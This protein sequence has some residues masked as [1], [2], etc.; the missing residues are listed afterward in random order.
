M[1]LLHPSWCS[2]SCCCLLPCL[3]VLFLPSPHLP[4]SQFPAH[5]EEQVCRAVHHST[6]RVDEL[7]ASIYDDLRT[8][9]VAADAGAA[10]GEQKRQEAEQPSPLGSKENHPQQGS[11]GGEAPTDKPAAGG[12]AAEEPAGGEGG[13]EP[14]TAKKAEGGAAGEQRSGRKA[15]TPKA[16][17]SRPLLRT[18]IIEVGAGGA[19][20]AACRAASAAV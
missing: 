14:A 6:A 16:P 8:A 17:V 4:A 18:Y 12:E 1:R 11:A 15:K 7:V 2:G 9:A 10:Q 3:T 13:P 19:R 5:L 20:W